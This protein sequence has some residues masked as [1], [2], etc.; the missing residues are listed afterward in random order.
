[1][2]SLFLKLIVSL[3]VCSPDEREKGFAALIDRRSEKWM[4]VQLVLDQLMV[5]NF[6]I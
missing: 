6:Q 3:F 1:M 4:S 2:V 5:T